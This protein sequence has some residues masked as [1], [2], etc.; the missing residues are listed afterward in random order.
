METKKTTS[1]KNVEIKGYSANQIA[2]VRNNQPQK[3]SEKLSYNATQSVD[4]RKG[5]SPQMTTQE[6]NGSP[7]KEGY[8]AQQMVH[9]ANQPTQQSKKSNSNK[10][11]DDKK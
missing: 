5:Y 2:E 10:N 9:T 1:K 3:I 8:N 11:S 4:I 6:R 7:I